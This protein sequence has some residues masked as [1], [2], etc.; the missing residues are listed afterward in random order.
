MHILWLQNKWLP[1]KSEK[2]HHIQTCC[3]CYLDQINVM[4]LMDQIGWIFFPSNLV[5]STHTGPVSEVSGGFFV[6]VY[7]FP[8]V[9]KH[10]KKVNLWFARKCQRW[11]YEC[12]CRTDASMQFKV[13]ILLPDKSWLSWEFQMLL[14]WDVILT[15]RLL[16]N[17]TVSIYRSNLVLLQWD[18]KRYFFKCTLEL[19]DSQQ[20]CSASCCFSH[21]ALI[22]LLIL[23]L[24]LEW[25]YG[26]LMLI[27]NVKG[28]RGSLISNVE[29]IV[30]GL[31]INISS[32]LEL[33]CWS[34]F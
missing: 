29:I 11:D 19:L 32:Y 2:K 8:L 31:Q 9:F 13:G 20:Q 22:Q 10:I 30:W 17:V 4:N 18:C 16:I 14:F 21:N 23:N 3:H 1:I 6:C 24:H 25:C 33:C 28:Q 5:V 27:V 34:I 7:S 15:Q 26:T 12:L